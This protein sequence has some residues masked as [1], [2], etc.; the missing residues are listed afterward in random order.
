MSFDLA[1][2]LV[3]VVA[4]ILY[5]ALIPGRSR[6]WFLFVGSLI[7]VFW[8]QPPLPIR[9]SDFVLP[10]ATLVLTAAAW[11]LT[12]LGDR[13]EGKKSRR[14]D[15]FGIGMMVAVI[16]GLAFFRY[17]SA[18]YRLTASR[19]PSPLAV[20][21][22]LALFG[23]A[24]ACLLW[25][26]SR[27]SK[28]DPKQEASPAARKLLS[29]GLILI[30][31]LFVILKTESLSTEV[32]K[33]WRS[34]TGQDTTLASPIDLQ[35]LGFSFVAF[36]LLHTLRDRQTGLL[37][38]LSL[39]EYVSYVLFFPAYTAGPIDRAE[40]FIKDYRALPLIRGMDPARI[41]L[42]FQRILIGLFKKFVIADLLVQGVSLNAINASQTHSTA[43]MWVLLYGYALRIYFDFGG[44]SDIAI[45]IGI[46]FGIKLPEN[47]DRPYL[48][49]SITAFWQSWH[50][51][52]S[53]WVRFYVFTP[54]SRWMLRKP[55]RPPTN[56]IVLT[57]HLS[58]M[59]V[60]GLWH[61]VTW[62]FFIWGIWHG[63]ALFVHKVWSDRTR[64]WYRH[65]GERPWAKRGWTV[66]AWF[67][68]LNYVVLGW[69][70]FALPSVS[71]S[72]EVFERLFGLSG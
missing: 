2:I 29:A 20:A 22:A 17:V 65:I 46:L 68:T 41:G 38:S 60:I 10:A 35:W 50:I 26:V 71:Q 33:F 42:G 48:K 49:S 37:P 3:F 55:W 39:K 45:G 72:T 16:V 24:L 28:E 15:L 36:R 63:L 51:T 4:A 47:F 6:S 61:G 67:V 18:D 13:E 64:K 44:Y 23:S 31:L 53:S 52:L 56:V 43:S 69:V 57:A 40:R 70:W 62:N 34:L 12:R 54:L 9:F 59:A 30:V 66:L 7:A 27:R 25:I 19:P 1:A 14:E 8:L 11:A 58:T 32:S 21:L 5:A